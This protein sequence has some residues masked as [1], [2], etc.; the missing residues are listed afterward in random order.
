MSSRGLTCY[1]GW[2]QPDGRGGA[3]QVAR[4]RGEE[5]AQQAV[6]VGFNGHLMGVGHEKNWRDGNLHAELVQIVFRQEL[7]EM[8]LLLLPLVYTSLL[9]PDACGKLPAREF[10]YYDYNDV[11]KVCFPRHDSEQV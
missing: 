5:H 2:T 10:H 11:F 6:A 7:V 1:G 9:P 4:S 8:S 3:G